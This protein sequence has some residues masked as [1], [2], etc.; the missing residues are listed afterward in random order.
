MR[1]NT[2]ELKVIVH[3]SKEEELPEDQKL[4]LCKFFELLYKVD[5]RLKR[6]ARYAKE[7]TTRPAHSDKCPSDHQV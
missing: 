4:R 3:E 5:Q 6:E 1:K 2:R 7:I